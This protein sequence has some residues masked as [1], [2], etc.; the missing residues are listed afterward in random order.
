MAMSRPSR[1][2]R[3]A[4]PLQAS[5]LLISWAGRDR[6][7]PVANPTRRAYLRLARRG[8]EISSQPQKGGRRPLY[9]QQGGAT[10]PPD[11]RLNLPPRNRL[12]HLHHHL[13][14]L[15]QASARIWLDANAKDLG[16]LRVADHRAARQPT[17][18][19]RTDSTGAPTLAVARQNRLALPPSPDRRAQCQPGRPGLG[20]CV[21]NRYLRLARTSKLS[22]V[23]GQ[24]SI[25][26]V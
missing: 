6:V 11:H 25:L 20:L 14:R 4:R 8:F 2:L 16:I 17:G 9:R 26:V 24:V 3:A 15:P 10:H 21:S 23:R 13:R 22:G 5:K 19:R 7:E 18:D 1:R 12:H